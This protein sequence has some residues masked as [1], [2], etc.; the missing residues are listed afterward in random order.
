MSKTREGEFPPV[1][2]VQNAYDMG[3]LHCCYYCLNTA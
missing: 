3:G 1:G 2:A